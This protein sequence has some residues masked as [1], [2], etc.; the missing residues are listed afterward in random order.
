MYYSTIRDFDVA[1]GPGV[2]VSLFVSGC[3][4]KCEGCFQPETWNPK[5]GDLFLD[6]DLDHIIQSLKPDYID[7]I[8]ILGGDPLMRYNIMKVEEIITRIRN[9][10][11]R[12]KTI[13]LYT[14]YTLDDIINSINYIFHEYITTPAPPSMIIATIRNILYGIDYLVDGPFILDKK[15]MRLQ[16]RGSSNQRLIDM[17]ETIVKN[18]IAT[19]KKIYH[20]NRFDDTDYIVSELNLDKEYFKM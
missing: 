17:N 3:S 10:Y 2:R 7:G 5:Y 15:D 14:G 12:R 6:K 1:N 8:T 11:G 9:T 4:H 20:K 13:W 19:N 16:F 18:D